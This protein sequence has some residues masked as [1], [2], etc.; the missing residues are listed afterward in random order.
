MPG[1]ILT[2]PSHSSWISRTLKLRHLAHPS[3]K[4]PTN[5]VFTWSERFIHSQILLC[6]SGMRQKRK[7]THD[8]GSSLGSPNNEDFTK[9]T[10]RATQ[11][12]CALGKVLDFFFYSSENK[13]HSLACVQSKNDYPKRILRDHSIEQTWTFIQNRLQRFNP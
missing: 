13:C 2:L 4:P 5:C 12:H 9:S 11:R 6:M 8:K 1:M 3:C 7:W 10:H